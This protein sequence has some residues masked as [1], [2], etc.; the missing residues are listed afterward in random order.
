MSF[1][2][3]ENRRLEDDHYTRA[4]R[5]LSQLHFAS[6]LEAIDVVTDH[7]PK[8]KNKFEPKRLLK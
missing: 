7:R 5:S 1:A 3:V 6:I 2:S 8:K 4:R